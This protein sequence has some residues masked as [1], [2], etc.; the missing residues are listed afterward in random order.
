MKRKLFFWALLLAVLPVGAK[1]SPALKDAVILIIRHAEK[2]ESGEGLS[3]TG[4]ERAKN[5]V[6]YYKNYAVNSNSLT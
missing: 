6:N 3:P 2:P 1:D 4:E 5:Y